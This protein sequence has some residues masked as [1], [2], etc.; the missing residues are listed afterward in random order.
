MPRDG[1]RR[2]PMQ[3]EKLHE[4]GHREMVSCGVKMD[5]VAIE[6]DAGVIR[7][8]ESRI[9]VEARDRDAQR[10]ASFVCGFQDVV[11]RLSV[12]ALA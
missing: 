3:I 7:L 4:L 2:E 6:L 11:P 10:A 5:A 8:L 1:A 12:G 9:E